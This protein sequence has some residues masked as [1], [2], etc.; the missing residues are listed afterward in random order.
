MTDPIRW[1]VGEAVIE[2]LISD[3]RLKRRPSFNP[4]LNQAAF[5]DLEKKVKS[6]RTLIEIEDYDSSVSLAHEV[7]RK[8]LTCLLRAQGLDLDSVAGSHKTVEE[9]TLA[10]FGEKG[11]PLHELKTDIRDVRT[12]RHDEEYLSEITTITRQ[13]AEDALEVVDDAV[14]VVGRLMPYLGLFV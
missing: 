3:G 12:L 4:E 13:D 10:Q 11:G 7:I 1:T 5:G 2:E 9:A 8:A 6:V 14:E